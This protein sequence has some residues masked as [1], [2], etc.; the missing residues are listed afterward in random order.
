MA[1]QSSMCKVCNLS[2]RVSIC[3]IYYLLGRVSMISTVGKED[4]SEVEVRSKKGIRKVSKPTIQQTYNKYMGGV[5]RFDQLCS[6]YPFGRKNKKWYQTLWHFV[7]ETAL[8]NGL[9]CYNIQNPNKKLQPRVFR[10]HVIDGL[11]KGLSRRTKIRSLGS[12]PTNSRLTERHFPSQIS[13]KGKKPNCV[14]CSIL[15]SKCKSKG[16]GECK[17]KQTTYFC[18][19]CLE[20]PTLCIIPCYKIYHTQVRYRKVCK[21]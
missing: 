10:Q 7:I 11:V 9:I 17:R 13:D 8:I 6:T 15:P 19:D 4:C 21:C 16:K 20:N 18:D 3:R 14:V 2:A 5:D 1:L 12:N